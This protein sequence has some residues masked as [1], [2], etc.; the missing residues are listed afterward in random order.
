MIE[1]VKNDLL[2]HFLM[3]L[4]A[5]SEDQ[6]LRGTIVPPPFDVQGKGRS[7]Q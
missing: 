1:Q 5:M 7:K 6:R 3:F 4:K 2:N